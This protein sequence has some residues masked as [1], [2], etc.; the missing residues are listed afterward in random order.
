M[1]QEAIRS[2]IGFN[3]AGAIAV[4]NFSHSMAMD[5]EGDVE[6]PDSNQF[7]VANWVPLLES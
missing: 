2:P 3:A 4:E 6:L 7:L 1:C 5:P